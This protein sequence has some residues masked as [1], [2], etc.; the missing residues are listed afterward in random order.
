[1]INPPNSTKESGPPVRR[2]TAILVWRK[3]NDVYRRCLTSAER[4]ALGLAT[5]G[6]TLA[7]LCEANVELL[8]GDPIAELNQCFSD[9]W[10]TQCSRS[11]F[12]LASHL[13]SAPISLK[14]RR[15]RSMIRESVTAA[16]R[17][18]WKNGT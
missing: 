14:T 9:G 12:R 16:A 10:V 17:G 7:E 2:Q 18:L 6:T 15:C 5:R 11:D 13:R 1:M 3:S 8:D 4:V